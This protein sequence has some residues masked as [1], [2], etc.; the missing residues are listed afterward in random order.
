MTTKSVIFAL[1][2]P[3]FSFFIVSPLCAEWEPPKDGL[4]TEAQVKGYFEVSRTLSRAIDA[5]VK[6]TQG[7]PNAETAAALLS[8][9]DARFKASLVKAGLQEKE[10]QW[11][12]QK[13][14]DARTVLLI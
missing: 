13:V 1:L 7:D 12:D 4:M 3:A 2:V 14:G 9:A 8:D 11:L 10:Y 5:G 6:A